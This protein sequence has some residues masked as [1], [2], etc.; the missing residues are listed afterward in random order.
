[1]TSTEEKTKVQ[2]L[3]EMALFDIKEKTSGKVDGVDAGMGAALAFARLETEL[4]YKV[5]PTRDGAQIQNISSGNVQPVD[6]RC[7]EL[8]QIL[9]AFINEL[10]E[11]YMT[12]AAH[13]LEANE[14]LAKADDTY[15]GLREETRRT[16]QQ[17]MERMATMR[18]QD[19]YEAGRQAAINEFDEFDVQIGDPV[20]EMLPSQPEPQTAA[21]PIHEAPVA[22]PIELA[23]RRGATKHGKNPSGK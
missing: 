22:D 6:P 14:R 10:V 16:H 8:Q 2:T 12:G 3:V 7:Y 15:T 5:L 11:T 19:G 1:M 4:G 13:L 23:A 17:A 18:Y 9:I 20:T 21:I